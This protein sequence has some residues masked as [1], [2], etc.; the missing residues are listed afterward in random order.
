LK[1]TSA[2]ATALGKEQRELKNF[3]INKPFQLR[4]SYYFVAMS[5][6]LVGLLMVFMNSYLDDIR[7]ILA[8]I[9]GLPMQA[10]IDIEEK[11]SHLINT[12]YGFL[13]LSLLASVFYGI[14]IS[15]RIAG[16]MVAIL[17]FIKSLKA[18][19]YDEKRSL[20]PYDELI[21]IMDSL[22]DLADHLKKK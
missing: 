20:R 12:A 4:M 2:G 7:M 21:P 3:I 13:F 22:H 9:S 8:N 10:Q 1:N 16:P 6:G 15:H 5:V 11:L 14:I 19:L 18:G 17:Q